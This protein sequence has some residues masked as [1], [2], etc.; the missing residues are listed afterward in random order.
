[1][2]GRGGVRWREGVG[3]VGG[4][5]WGR[6]VGGKGWGRYVGGKGWNKMEVHSV[7]QVRMNLHTY[8]H[9][10][11][12]GGHRRIE[13]EIEQTINGMKRNQSHDRTLTRSFLASSTYVCIYTHIRIC[14]L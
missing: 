10:S 3:Q 2:E 6:Y 12:G 9:W 5:G 1:M 14:M 8:I 13:V 7:E 11:V 4:K